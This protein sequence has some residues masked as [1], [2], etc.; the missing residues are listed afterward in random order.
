MFVIEDQPNRAVQDLTVLLMMASPSQGDGASGTPAPVQSNRQA[1]D[2]GNGTYGF[3]SN[4]WVS[5]RDP[6]RTAPKDQIVTPKY[7]TL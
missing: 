1:P 5:N 2:V 7:L 3:T 4:L 6:K